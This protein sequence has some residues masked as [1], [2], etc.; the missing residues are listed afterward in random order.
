MNAIAAD[1]LTQKP[2]AQDFQCATNHPGRAIRLQSDPEATPN[3]FKLPPIN[4]LIY[5]LI[6]PFGQW[7]AICLT[8]VRHFSSGAAAEGETG[9]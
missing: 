1:L 8:V 9:L 7:R 5:R 3:G 2:Y 4:G 6:P